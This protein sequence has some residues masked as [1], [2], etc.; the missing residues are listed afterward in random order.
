MPT[1]K[2]AGKAEVHLCHKPTPSTVRQLEGNTHLAASPEEWRVWTQHLGLHLLRLPSEERPS[3]SESQRRVSTRPTWLQLRKKQFLI[4]LQGLTMA[5]PPGFSAE[6]AEK[7]PH[8]LDCSSLQTG[9]A[10]GCYLHVLP[11]AHSR[12][13]VCLWKEPV[14]MCSGFCNCCPGSTL[15][16]HPALAA[17]G[18]CLWVPQDSSK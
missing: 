4:Y 18:L 16:D 10:S 1:L 9:E 15:L 8:L 14:H 12:S 5:V 7:C 3:H 17:R 2:R 13:L 6:T 11:L